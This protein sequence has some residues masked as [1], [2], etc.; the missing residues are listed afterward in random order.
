MAVR[1]KPKPEENNALGAYFYRLGELD[2]AIA[3]FRAAVRKAPHHTIYWT[4]L[5]TALMDAGDLVGAEEALHRALR[6]RPNHQ[7]ALFA[8]GQLAD[9]RGQPDQAR[10][11]YQQVVEIDATS[12]FGERAE[13]KLS[14]WRWRRPVDAGRE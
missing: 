9:L 6:L 10:V 1:K 3:Q 14:G 4:N 11:Y 5:G 13:E 12:R 8:L 7:A 2:L